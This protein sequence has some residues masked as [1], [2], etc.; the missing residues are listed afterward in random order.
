MEQFKK[1]LDVFCQLI[2]KR[3]LVIQF[4]PGSKANAI[5]VRNLDMELEN[6]GLSQHEMDKYL[7]KIINIY[8]QIY[9]GDLDDSVEKMAKDWQEDIN[10]IKEK[11]DLIKSCWNRLKN[12]EEQSSLHQQCY[13]VKPLSAHC[14]VETKHLDHDSTKNDLQYLQE[15]NVG[16][17]TLIT[18]ENVPYKADPKTTSFTVTLGELEYLIRKMSELK[19]RLLHVEK[20]GADNENLS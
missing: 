10:E 11:A 8:Q 14:E 2:E 17:I 19:E 6:A 7:H 1:V 18:V 5:Q 20:E 15:V 3:L 13:Y 16:T 9:S 12:L 4:N